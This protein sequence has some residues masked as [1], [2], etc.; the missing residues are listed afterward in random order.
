MTKKPLVFISYAQFDNDFEGGALSRFRHMLSRTLQFVSGG[1]IAVFQE[2]ADV[3]LGQ[4]IEERMSQSLNEVMV[5]VPVLTP[6]FFKDEGCKK[7]LTRFLERERQ[8]ERNDLV[9]GVLYQQVPGLD[10][11]TKPDDPLLRDLAQRRMLDW[12]PL[13]G[14]E[15][16]DPAVRQ[17]LERMARRIIAILQELQ[18]AMPPT[19]QP[20][21]APTPS[22]TVASPPTVETEPARLT[23]RFAPTPD[24]ATITC[25]WESMV[26]GSRRSSFALPYPKADLPTVIKALD[27]AQHPDYP[28][29]GPVFSPEEQSCLEAHTLWQQG[30]VPSDIHQRVGQRLYA[31]LVQDRDSEVALST[32]R[33]AARS[34]G[35]ALTYLL[36]FP[37]DAV[38]LA[39]LPW[40]ALWDSRQAVLL[41]RGGRQIDSLERYLDLDEALSPPLPVG[42]KLHILAL[43][44][45]AGIS[46]SVREEER[47]ARVQSWDALK[48]QGLLEWD[49][50]APVT[51]RALDDRMRQG[52]TPDI[53]HYYGHGTYVNGQGCLLFDGATP[54]KHEFVSAQRLAALLGEI[55]LIVI[56]A[57]QSAMVQESPGQRGLLTGVA[58]A[59]SA[60]SEAV[61]AMQLTVR[62]SAATRFAEVFYAELARGRSLQ[63]AVAE[64]R[65]SLYVIESDGASWYVPTLYIR[66]RE[67]KP[68]Y[69]VQPAPVQEAP[70]VLPPAQVQPHT[71]SKPQE[72]PMRQLSVPEINQLVDLLLACPAMQETTTRNDVLAFLQDNVRN[73]ISRR[74]QPRADVFN[75][76][77]TCNAYP[78]AL[79]DVVAGIRA[80][81]GG[82]ACM[83]TLDTFWKNVS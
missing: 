65:R 79:N 48:A 27:A 35:Q 56:H 7:V 63:A 72:Q 10:T 18:A 55:R 26:G 69:F 74:D 78:G 16:S 1:E 23:L 73:A 58:P 22:P 37:P 8:L 17:E 64:A 36:R 47:T 29:D 21:P 62:I 20:A 41:S 77:R 13:R 54:G 25:T 9:L 12:Q 2:D 31:A 51:A 59:L 82:M 52:P 28:L 50:L 42:K 70:P 5:L 83:Q 49:E 53:L 66:T 43:S 14:K 19:P 61:V 67:Q 38:E 57:C 81:N 76:V 60:V 3:E 40:E 4:R 15:F 46:K 30:R 39:A 11:T 68:L 6:S 71:D 45:Q 24:G 33:N 75:I 34:Q 80:F 44:P 32:V